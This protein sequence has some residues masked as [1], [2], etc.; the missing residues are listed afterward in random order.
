MND[1][2][3]N[4]RHQQYHHQ[5][6]ERNPTTADEHQQSQLGH[7]KHTNNSNLQA[8]QAAAEAISISR[9]AL[10]TTI[11]QGEQLHH[12][13]DLRVRNEY[14]VKKSE[15][16][17]RGMTWSGRVKNLF[18]PDIA[19][20]SKSSKLSFQQ[21]MK[22][23]ME[24]SN[25]IHSDGRAR[26]NN[27]TFDDAVD[28]QQYTLRD[29][30]LEILPQAS[31]FTN[32]KSNVL[33]LSKC[34]NENDY[35]TCLDIC[36][37]LQ[38]ESEHSLI[39]FYHK[40]QEQAFNHHN[41]HNGHG[42]LTHLKN[43]IDKIQLEFHQVQE[44]H[45]SLVFTP[46]EI[47]DTF[48][49]RGEKNISTAKEATEMKRNDHDSVKQA[50]FLRKDNPKKSREQRGGI[51]SSLI[52]NHNS[53]T[54]ELKSQYKEQEDHLNILSNHLQ[55]LQQNSTSMGMILNEQSS[56]LDTLNDGTDDLVESTKMISR[57]AERIRYRTVRII[58]SVLF[59]FIAYCSNIFTLCIPF[60]RCGKFL[61]QIINVL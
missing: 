24:K 44:L 34:E 5:H 14:I 18:T 15:R 61:D 51:V 53:T 56:V 49:K 47:N 9:S 60:Y 7:Q 52:N 28:V 19:P 54:S 26:F 38:T 2:N 8:Q 45:S 6:N 13:N 36:N 42:E 55:E 48:R 50:L 37:T 3:F 58:L 29:V 21:N 10:H 12:C 4:N 1:N 31:L 22:C 33:L 57:K 16:L 32:Y 11:S 17:I 43:W 20:P 27:D 41:G 39:G 23:S 46:E 40:Q 59:V 35:Q 30:P 25:N